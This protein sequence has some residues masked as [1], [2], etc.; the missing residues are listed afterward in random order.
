M[1][2]SNSA[3]AKRSQS[4]I[5]HSENQIVLIIRKLLIV[6]HSIGCTCQLCYVA[7]RAAGNAI[8]D[9]R[10]RIAE[11]QSH[12]VRQRPHSIRS[13]YEVTSVRAL[14][15]MREA[16]SLSA[17]IAS[18]VLIRLHLTRLR[19]LSA[20]RNSVPRLPKRR[21]IRS[22]LETCVCIFFAQ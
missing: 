18:D 19:S 15:H 22:L 8:C 10:V 12:F 1:K 6:M 4:K 7:I 21:E 16:A 3:G 13:I 11:M 5:T 14:A 17:L 9:V 2:K 20:L